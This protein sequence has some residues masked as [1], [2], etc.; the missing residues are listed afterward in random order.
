MLL[1]V[2]PFEL[3]QTAGPSK[4]RALDFFTVLPFQRNTM[5]IEPVKFPETIKQFCVVQPDLPIYEKQMT[6]DLSN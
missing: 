2:G 1:W 4:T 6:A 5:Q 3:S